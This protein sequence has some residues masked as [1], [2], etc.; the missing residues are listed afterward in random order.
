MCSITISFFLL[1]IGFYQWCS[2]RMCEAYKSV[3]VCK[4]CK[5]LTSHLPLSTDFSSWVPSSI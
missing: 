2:R 3:Y 5:V 4:E 1:L